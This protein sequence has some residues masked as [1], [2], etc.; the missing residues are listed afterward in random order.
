MKQKDK[1]K[2]NSAILRSDNYD[3]IDFKL[4]LLE[5]I[6]FKFESGTHLSREELTIIMDEFPSA[7]LETEM[8]LLLESLGFFKAEGDGYTLLEQTQLRQIIKCHKKDDRS[9]SIQEL[10]S[11]LTDDS[12]GT[13]WTTRQVK[14]SLKRGL[15]WSLEIIRIAKR[16]NFQGLPAF[17]ECTE[18]GDEPLGILQAGTCNVDN[19]CL[20][21]KSFWSSVPFSALKISDKS[22]LLNILLGYTLNCQLPSSHA[23]VADMSVEEKEWNRGGLMPYEDQPGSFHPTVESTADLVLSLSIFYHFYDDI[24]ADVSD[25]EYLKEN[26]GQAILAGVGFLLRMELADGGWGIYKYLNDTITVP[27]HQNPSY[28][29]ICAFGLVK[30]CGVIGNL[31]RPELYA[32]INNAIKR[33]VDFLLKHKIEVE[34]VTLWAPYFAKEYE[35]VQDLLEA[36]TKVYRSLFS[37]T[38]GIEEYKAEVYP[39][40]KGYIGFIEKN[41]TPDYNLLARY[42]FRSPHKD[43]LNDS[44]N[45]WEIRMDILLSINLLEWRELSTFTSSFT[46]KLWENIEATVGAILLDQHNEHG[47]WDDP[48]NGRPFI[49]STLYAME[50]LNTYLTIV[51]QITKPNK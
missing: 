43:G 17:W 51:H 31:Q 8:F 14:N 27:A 50:V 2:L 26:I 44:F 42:S 28:L 15:E 40:L 46:S 36:S 34:G 7:L 18:K 32:E 35:S 1:V 29:T 20:M 5:S 4:F 45:H 33:Y 22:E 41:W 16:E 30:M 39:M 3:H 9:I 49:V 6:V 24:E 25:L 21:S 37:I 19:L 47:H 38:K 12:G 10:K 23:E 13:A 11:L 48:D